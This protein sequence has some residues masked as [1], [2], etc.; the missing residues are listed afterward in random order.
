MDFTIASFSNISYMNKLYPYLLALIKSGK[1]FLATA[2]ELVD[3]W[4]KRNRVTI[5]ESEDQICLM[6]PDDLDSFTLCLHG[7]PKI[8]EVAEMPAKV[9][10]NQIQ[11]TNVKADSIAVIVVEGK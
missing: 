8:K 7:N 9:M 2:G 3:W 10:G 4:E 6:F 5:N 1:T 11:F